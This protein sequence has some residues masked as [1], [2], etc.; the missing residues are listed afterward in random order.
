VLNASAA[1][2]VPSNAFKQLY[3]ENQRGVQYSVLFNLILTY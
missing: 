3:D 2:L 1:A